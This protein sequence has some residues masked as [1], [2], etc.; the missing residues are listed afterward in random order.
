[1]EDRLMK[2]YE[3]NERY[4]D[5]KEKRAWLAISFY[6]AFTLGIIRI[7]TQDVDISDRIIYSSCFTVCHIVVCLLVL[8]VSISEKKNL[9][10]NR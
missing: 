6:A 1:M 7:F 8:S 5:T 2:I 3:L 10:K 9:S 4:H